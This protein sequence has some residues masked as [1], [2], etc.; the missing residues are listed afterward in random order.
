MGE[1]EHGDVLGGDHGFEA[2]G[3]R[4]VPRLDMFVHVHGMGYGKVKE[5]KADGVDVEFF[6]S[7]GPGGLVVKSYPLTRVRPK[8]LPGGHS[9]RV[10][11]EGRWH[12]AR[13]A[14]VN[15]DDGCAAVNLGEGGLVNVGLRDVFVRCLGAPPDPLES[16]AD[17]VVGHVGHAVARADWM[18]LQYRL[19]AAVRGLGGLASSRVELH[20][21]QIEIASRVLRDPVQRYLLADEVGL[22]KTIEAGVV[23]RQHLID[24]DTARATLIVPVPLASQWFSELETKFAI[25]ELGADRVQIWTHHPDTWQGTP[26]SLLIIDEAHHLTA[27]AASPDVG[28]ATYVRLKELARTADRLLLMSATPLLHNEEAFLG[29]LHLIDPSLYPLEEL[30]GFKRRVEDKRE[31]ALRF[32]A[33]TPTSES[34][35][36][37]E[38]A[39]AFKTMFPEDEVVGALLDDVLSRIDAEMAS[40]PEFNELVRA[41]RVH[42]GE[43]YRLHQRVLR[44]R[45]DSAL[46]AG[47]PVRGRSGPYT[48]DGSR[49]RSQD[50]DVWTRDW[51]TTYSA[52]LD[53]G[54]L[55]RPDRVILC[56]LLER[57]TVHPDVLVGFIESWTGGSAVP[58]ADLTPVEE[59]AIAASRPTQRECDELDALRSLVLAAESD[60]PWAQ[61]VADAV[62]SF[63]DGER[64]VVFC[65]FTSA[66]HWLYDELAERVGA[67]VALFSR[68]E[69][70][71]DHFDRFAQ[72]S[73][74]ILVGDVSIEEGRNIQFAERLVHVHVPWNPNRLEQ[75][76]GR[77]D[78]FGHGGPVPQFVV[79]GGLLDDWVRLLDR[80]FGLF[81]ES[82]ASLQHVLD[83]GV[84]E[85][86]DLAVAEGPESWLAFADDL[87]NRL[88]AERRDIQQ[89]ENLESIE[90]ESSFAQSVY[91][92]LSQIESDEDRLLRAIEA[93]L[94]GNAAKGAGGL[95]FKSQIERGRPQS[96]RYRTASDG[97]VPE[98]ALVASFRPYLGKASSAHRNELIKYP[99]SAF[100]RPGDGF[101]E[102]IRRF[103]DGD[104]LGQ[105]FAMWRRASSDA[106]NFVASMHVR[107]E[108]SAGSAMPYLR[109]QGLEMAES[110]VQRLLDGLLQPSSH[111]IHLMLDGSP[112]PERLLPKIAQPFNAKSDESIA[113]R[114]LAR[115]QQELDIEWS[116]AWRA[117]G[118]TGLQLVGD[119]AAL[120]DR[121]T[122]ALLGLDVSFNDLTQKLRLRQRA[123]NDSRHR[124]RL[125]RELAQAAALG[126]AMRSAIQQAKPCVEAVGLIMLC[127]W[128][129]EE[130]WPDA[131]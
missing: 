5:V 79:G 63:D 50:L 112:P 87:R 108:A 125:D 60:R 44:T 67:G 91:L 130:V 6:H 94:C 75:R 123:E 81:S 68:G 52:R 49:L 95:G 43:T 2:P 22:G 127:L 118:T 121:R 78:R 106:P 36:L 119:A 71:D 107:L 80:G 84:A 20:P 29:M 70:S 98:E 3:S 28:H 13:I 83:G 89:L 82:I 34:F 17:G 86:I 109:E 59:D 24:D 11:R 77:A 62:T 25:D 131:D 38:H 35:V 66:A 120:S 12:A 113:P 97:P 104:D 122:E 76:I 18:H 31:F 102:A 37:E 101:F 10:F 1:F 57:L 74:R 96:R 56:G 4:W 41:V 55:K 40:G 7:T 111:Q 128:R 88:E 117:I 14:F 42:L 99:S 93:W 61:R 103:T 23:L 73:A 48:M 33:F 124:F 15:D 92:D 45:R 116:D 27:H 47:F 51:F 58:V 72:G 54:R 26:G 46:G 110:T 85:A 64:V 19:R 32:Q 21:H 65:G 129:P 16:I 126:A 114:H 105:T 8:P 30:E 39:E 53:R 9:C 115:L 100:F 90:A 69:E